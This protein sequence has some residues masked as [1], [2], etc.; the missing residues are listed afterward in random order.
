MA[1]RSASLL[2]AHALHPVDA[3]DNALTALAQRAARARIVLIGE[4]S[5]GTRDFYAM[6]AALTERLISAHG[7][8]AVALEADWPDTFRAH[9]YVTGRSDD[10]DANEALSGFRRFPAWM[11]RNETMRDFVAWLA[12]F[13]LALPPHDRAG[14]FGLDLY[15]LHASI[16]SVLAYLDGVDRVAAAQARARYGCFEHFGDSPQGYGLAVTQ[17]ADSCE[18]EAVAQL[19]DLRRQ[20]LRLPLVAGNAPNEELFSAEQN[21]RLVMNAER[22]YRAMYRGRESTWNLRDSHMADTLEALRERFGG[23][24]E[25]IVVW[26]HNSHLGDARATEMGRRGELNLGQLVRER[27]GRNAFA[28]GFSTF[29]GTV[30]AASDWDAPMERKRVR[31]A[32]PGSYERLFHESA[33]GRFYVDVAGEEAGQ[34][35][36]GPLLQRAIGVIYRPQTERWSH[37]FEAD[38][39]RQFDVMIHLDRTEALVPLD[40]SA[41]WDEG[42]PPETWPAAL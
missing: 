21:A 19:V 30:T 15:S 35:L 12:D 13:N 33:A 11:W 17:G 1:A 41:G 9:R 25:G 40:R 2:P 22:Y 38:L 26:A 4:A 3:G 14:L 37:Y 34:P 10:A 31:D 36:A 20:A 18:D 5:H 24:A 42:E 39:P 32:L 6:R 8:R 23:A 29:N 28:I 16:E 7:F 27:H